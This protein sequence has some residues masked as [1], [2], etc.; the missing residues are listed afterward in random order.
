MVL[1][2]VTGDIINI[3]IACCDEGLNLLNN[4][5][6]RFEDSSIRCMYSILINHVTYELAH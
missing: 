4:H 1:G 5:A 2:V 3:I 6:C